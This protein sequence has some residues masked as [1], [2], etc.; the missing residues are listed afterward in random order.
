MNILNF[1]SSLLIF[2]QT[3]L[4]AYERLVYVVCSKTW[5]F[6]V[7]RGSSMSM[8][9]TYYVMLILFFAYLWGSGIYRETWPGIDCIDYLYIYL[10]I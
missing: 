5:S 10:F 1:A 8:A 2:L 4:F 7:L 6:T 9:L 3:V